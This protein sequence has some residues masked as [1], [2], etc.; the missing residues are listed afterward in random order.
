MLRFAEN[1]NGVGTG[2]TGRTNLLAGVWA[3]V[4]SQTSPETTNPRG[5]GSTHLRSATASVNS[6]ARF[7]FGADLVQVVM[8]AAFYM[9]SL[10]TTEVYPFE[11]RDSANAAQVRVVVTSTGKIEVRRGTTATVIADSDAL[12]PTP[13]ITASAYHFIEVFLDVGNGASPADGSV[14]VRV[15]GVVVINA[16]S[17]DT[18]ATAITTVSQAAILQS[19]V[20]S[21]VSNYDCADLYCCDTTGTYN[22]TFLGD[23][24]WLDM[25]VNGD[26]VTTDWTRNTGATDFSCIS[27]TTPD[28]DT[29]YVEATAAA[30]KS[31]Y[32]LETLPGTV[33]EV[34]AVV[35][36]P[37]L[38][39]TD[40]G[41]AQ[42]QVSM[43]SGASVGSGTD[44][45]ITETYTYWRDTFETDPATGVPWTPT[46]FNAAQIRIEKT[47]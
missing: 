31:D 18:Q 28:A 46:S 38:R 36:K 37:M 9:P 21:G 34:L 26:T 39:K 19:P 14:I 22:T 41:A 8:G 16:S 42:V 11:I 7:V 15:N 47:V 29:T 44:R 1:F 17:V 6:I 32:D 40:A 12:S 5:L 10:P 2:A 4:G 24:Q 20:G 33:G 3:Q 43:V 35:S 25:N 23:T 27:D 45:A 30:Q 13:P